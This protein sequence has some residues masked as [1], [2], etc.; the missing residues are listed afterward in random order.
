M[1]AYHIH[2][3]VVYEGHVDINRF[4]RQLHHH[5]RNRLLDG[6]DAISRFPFSAFQGRP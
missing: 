1:G 5:G 3:R 2:V 4:F 6:T